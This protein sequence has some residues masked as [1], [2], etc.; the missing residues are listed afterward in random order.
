[1][2]GH[3]PI[4]CH[5]LHIDFQGDPVND[6][7]QTGHMRLYGAEWWP[8]LY[9]QTGFQRVF[10]EEFGPNKDLILREKRLQDYFIPVSHGQYTFAADQFCAFAPHVEQAFQ[11]HTLCTTQNGLIGTIPRTSAKGDK[12]AVLFGCD[13]PIVLRPAVSPAGFYKVVGICF[14]EGLMRGEVVEG[15]ETGTFMAQ[16]IALC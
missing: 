11:R 7:C 2:T 4:N 13:Y 16:D 5:R 6:I 14:V 12:I 3:I 15:I 1:V 10:N 8:K 9:E